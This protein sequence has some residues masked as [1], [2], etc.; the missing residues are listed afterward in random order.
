MF[1]TVVF[2]QIDLRFEA[3]CLETFDANF[4]NNPNIRF[5]KPIRPYCKRDVLVETYEVKMN[6][7]LFWHLQVIAGHKGFAIWFI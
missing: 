3:S 2:S 6:L 4:A 7:R 1:E 5:P